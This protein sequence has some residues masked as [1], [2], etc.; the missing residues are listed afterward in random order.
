MK[1]SD[2]LSIDLPCGGHGFCGR[3]RVRVLGA[4][5]P[6]TPEEAEKLSPARLKDGFRLA[7]MAEALG[8]VTFPDLN[9]VSDGKSKAVAMTQEADSRI[10]SGTAAKTA[11]KPQ[12]T[13]VIELRTQLFSAR[14]LASRAVPSELPASLPAHLGV[15]VDIGTTTIAA[16][17]FDLET[18]KL[19]AAKGQINPQRLFGF[20]VISRIEAASRGKGQALT[21]LIRS[22][23]SDLIP[24]QTER[25]VLTGNTTM[26]YLYEGLDPLPL[27]RAPFTMEHS[28]GE[29]LTREGRQVILPPTFSAYL[30][31][32]TACALL[33]SGMTA[34]PEKT[35]LLMDI[36]TNGELVLQH[37]GKLYA[38]S[39]AAGPALEGGKIASGMPSVPGAISHLDE[40]W[41]VET[42]DKQ[43][44][45]G[46]CGSGLIDLLAV[47]RKKGLVD[48]SG[49]LEESPFSAVVWRTKLPAFTQADIRE[50]QLCIASIGAA[51]E[52]LLAISGA[53]KIDH[54]YLSGG[55]GSGIDPTSARQI[56]LIPASARLSALGNAAGAG[57]SMLLLQPGYLDEM[58]RIKDRLTVIEI[59]GDPA[60]EEAFLRHMSLMPFEEI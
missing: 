29:L 12:D 10:A 3:C 57:A 46:Y 14:T 38:A 16:Y 34:H 45:K 11:S 54:L 41:H 51:V 27:S 1:L 15:A 47:L 7:C 59:G 8:P 9:L 2:I 35:S 5:S 18:H 55:F 22:T 60:F 58:V 40:G 30:G 17:Y 25:V 24:R 20:D 13:P 19:L 23:V 26:L 42:I 21:T 32:D 44:V 37:E 49:R 39:A 31:A 28:F 6:V 4:L 53:S 33:A 36:G 48:V 56:G 52:R 50:L 43:P